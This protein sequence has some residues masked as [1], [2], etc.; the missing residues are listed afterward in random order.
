MNIHKLTLSIG[1]ALAAGSGL[2]QAS[3]DY[4]PAIWRPAYSGHWYTTGNGH[5]FHVVHDMEG[6]YWGTISYLQQSGTSVSV[7]YCINGKVDNGS[8]S[9]PGE[10][11]QMVSEAYYGW[12]ALCWNRYSTGT[13]HEGF[14]SNP[15]W[16]TEAMYQSSSGVTRHVSDKFGW[17]KDRNHIVAHGEDSNSAWV[18]WAGSGLGID[19][20]CNNH[21]DPGPYWNWSHYMTLV[22]GGGTP[23]AVSWGAG[24]IDVFARGADG[25]LQHK[26][27]NGAWNGWEN[28]GGG[29]LGGPAVASWGPNRLDVFVRG[30]DSAIFQK[31]WDGSGWSGFSTFSGTVTSDPAAVS[32]GA[33]RIDVFA[34]GSDATLRHMWF[35]GAWHPWENLGGGMIGGPTVASWG[36]GRL[37]VFVRG[38]DDACWHRGYDSGGGWGPWET[39]GGGFNSDFGAVSWGPGRIDFFGRGWDNEMYHKWYANG[40]FGT[41]WEAQGGGLL[42]GPDVA[43]WGSG[44]LDV[45]IRGNN[46]A[47]YTKYWDGSAWSG[48]VSLGA[49]P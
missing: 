14:A 7:H 48:W 11:T 26:A 18:A 17:A 45:F 34:R 3:T 29:I 5:R 9:A 42:S 15:A 27:Y 44:R 24:R 25:S 23:A 22:L 46:N 38:T 16:Y 33:N 19:P 4:G 31:T 30:T 41:V 39:L 6:Y 12:H 37:D 47:L 43:S 28:L 13:E 2:A 32:W 35:D 1:L 21:T 8:D 40:A 49:M 36:S 10:V 20:T